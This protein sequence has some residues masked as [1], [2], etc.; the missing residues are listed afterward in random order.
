MRTILSGRCRLSLSILLLLLIAPSTGHAATSPDLTIFFSSD[1]CGMIRRCGCTDGQLGGLSARASY[2]KSH[3]NKRTLVL[4]AGDTLFD[5]LNDPRDM[6]AFYDLKATVLMKAMG[7]SGYD[8]ILPGEYDLEFG[9]NFLKRKALESGT[10]LICANLET[11]SGP[12]FEGSVVKK[13]GRITIGITGVI[14]N[15]FPYKTFP[16]IF[17]D[18]IV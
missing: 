12:A 3:R 17:K 9:L 1:T 16:A 6:K 7:Q 18:F 5:G 2:I 4:D 8:A 11:A 15:K 13:I 14:D 10:R